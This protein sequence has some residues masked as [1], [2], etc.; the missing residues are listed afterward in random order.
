[1]IGLLGPRYTKPGLQAGK[2]RAHHK[3]KQNTEMT[4]CL[5][6]GYSITRQF[7]V[8]VFCLYLWYARFF[9]PLVRA[10]YILGLTLGNAGNLHC[11][12]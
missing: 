11:Y 12:K 1:M 8:A 5:Q 9:P 10:K 2:N 3:Y 6:A 4:D 7:V